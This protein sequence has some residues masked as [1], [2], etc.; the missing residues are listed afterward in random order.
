MTNPL[1]ERIQKIAASGAIVCDLGDLE[2]SEL[3]EQIA[4]LR[5]IELL[6]LGWNIPAVQNNRV[7]WASD[8]KRPYRRKPLSLS[9]IQSLSNLR[10]LDLAGW[11]IDLASLDVIAKLKRLSHLQTRLPHGATLSFLNSLPDLSTLSLSGIGTNDLTPLG[12]LRSLRR[13]EISGDGLKSLEALS[14]LAG[15]RKISIDGGQVSDYRPLRIMKELR[16]AFLRSDS[17]KSL[18]GFQGLSKLE[19]LSAVDGGIQNLA[20]LTGLKQLRELTFQYC[21]ELSDLS[22]VATMPSLCSLSLENCYRI[23]DWSPL[24]KCENLE[25]LRLNSC[26]PRNLGVLSRHPRVQIIREGEPPG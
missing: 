1:V 16:S 22:A 3:P 21:S 10:A 2:F 23:S 11:E 9:A 18:D 4:S 26:S 25:V 7:T 20:P 19:S 15:V 24:L 14:E 12:S 17:H 5:K 13:L 8:Y 6:A